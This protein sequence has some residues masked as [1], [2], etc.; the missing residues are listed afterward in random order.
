MLE[1]GGQLRKAATDYEIP[2][3]EWLDLSTGINP[4]G[5]PIPPELPRQI[6]NRL[7]E[8]NDGL[9]QAAQ[10]Y[11]QASRLLAVAGS[12]ASIQA[13]P[14]LRKPSTVLISTPAYA[15]HAHAWRIAGH[16]VRLCA[17]TPTEREIHDHDVVV[18]V[19]PNN[20]TGRLLPSDTLLRWH[21]TL[22]QKGGWLIVD[23]AFIDTTPEHSLAQH[24][25]EQGLIVLR[26]L[27]KFFGLAGA[28]VGFVLAESTLLTQLNEALGPWCISGPSRYIAQSA[29]RD[30]QWQRHTREALQTAQTRLNGLWAQHGLTPSGNVA[31]FQWVHTS[32]AFEIFEAF[33]HQGILLRYFPEPASIRC[34]LPETE[35]DWNRL[36]TALRDWHQ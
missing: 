14:K 28:R 17:E 32:K 34:G 1:H 33:A 35:A 15:E 5:W 2:L 9:H 4:L 25:P 22:Q 29:L 23:E 11:Y 21:H 10:T 26:S 7:P 27:G 30:T 13:L 3:S 16:R 18:I 31:L 6:W 20:P 12:Q 8:D 19:N 24:T 36:E